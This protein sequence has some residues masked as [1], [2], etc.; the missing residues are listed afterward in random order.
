MN[1]TNKKTKDRID[2]NL[3]HKNKELK[4]TNG[5][6]SNQSVQI[7]ELGTGFDDRKAEA[8]TSLYDKSPKNQ[9]NNKAT[10]PRPEPNKMKSY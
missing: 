3:S 5:Q 10:S 6:K 1:H 7:E 9:F 4:I 2:D 8:V